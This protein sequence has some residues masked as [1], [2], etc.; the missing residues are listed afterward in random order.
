MTRDK[1]DHRVFVL[2]M[3]PEEALTKAKMSHVIRKVAKKKDGEV[4]AVF[5]SLADAGRSEGCDRGGI[6]CVLAGKNKTAYGFEWE[7]VD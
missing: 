4:V 2:G 6:W 5:D 3:D 7:Y 1:V